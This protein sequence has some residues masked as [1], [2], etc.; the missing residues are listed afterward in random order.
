MSRQPAARCTHG[1]ARGSDSCLQR[2]LASQ[3]WCSCATAA[4]QG[5]A[6]LTS[7]AGSQPAARSMPVIPHQTARGQRLPAVAAPAASN[8]S[9]PR[10]RSPGAPKRTGAQCIDA[11]EPRNPTVQL[12]PHSATAGDAPPPGPP[13]RCAEKDWRLEFQKASTKILLYLMA[14]GHTVA[15]AAGTCG[16][17]SRHQYRQLLPSGTSCCAWW[18]PGTRWRLRR[19]RVAG[20][21]CGALL[22][23]MPRRPAA[24]LA[25]R[26]RVRPRRLRPH[27][28]RSKAGRTH[29]GQRPA[30]PTEV[31]GRPHPPRS[32]APR[33]NMTQYSLFTQVPSGK[34]SSG[35]VPAGG[36]GRGG[37]AGGQ[38]SG[39]LRQPA[40]ATG[41]RAKIG[42]EWRL[43][44]WGS[45]VRVWRRGNPETSPPAG[46]QTKQARTPAARH[47]P[48]LC[49]C[50][51]MRRAT[52]VRSWACGAAGELGSC[53]GA[54]DAGQCQAAPGAQ[55]RN[56]SPARRQALLP[57]HPS[58]TR[59]PACG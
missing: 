25:A 26:G 22:D 43:R 23:A 4:G 35:V 3:P 44:G 29:Q 11:A 21:A 12:R 5:W 38:A 15:P 20:D 34:M 18:P 58:P 39:S 33:L 31:K 52:S 40:G 37:Q 6:A 30:A 8:T 28:P 7:L 47:P 49:T 9:L 24:L 54:A 36:G 45:G 27:P 51:R 41:A 1:S 50:S 10:R 56:G 55:G 13:T 48:G 32:K 42:S 2:W 46:H 59:P 57:S 53:A 17:R 16:R 19:A 14:T